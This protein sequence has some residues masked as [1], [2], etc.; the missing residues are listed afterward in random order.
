MNAYAD[1]VRLPAVLSAPGDALLGAAAGGDTGVRGTVAAAVSSALAYM[2][3]MALNDYADRH[4]DAAERPDRPI[5][6]GRI[7]PERALALGAGLLVADLV[8]AGWG[9]GRRGVALSLA[10]TGA[11]LGYDF[12]AKDTVA[13]PGVMAACR[14]LDVQRGSRSFRAALLPAGLVAAHTYMITGVSRHEVDG[15]N[16]RVALSSVVATAAIT[17]AALGPALKAAVPTSAVPRPAAQESSGVRAAVPTTVTDSESRIV[18]MAAAA[19]YVLPSIRASLAAARDPSSSRLQRVVKTGVLGMLPLQGT[20][21]ATQ[22]RPATGAGMIV[23]WY[24]ARNLA[25]RRRVT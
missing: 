18:A 22:G 16:R 1:L 5:P 21:T 20:L 9:S 23:L 13:G 10:T 3:G 2:A 4:V 17:V 6:S 14:F 11:V 15:G 8:V 7:S 24:A 12:A 19:L 25:A